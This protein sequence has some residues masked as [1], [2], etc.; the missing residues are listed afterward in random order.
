MRRIRDA[1]LNLRDVAISKRLSRGVLFGQKRKKTMFGPAKSEEMAENI[2]IDTP[3][4]ARK[5]T[6]WLTREWNK[7]KKKGD[8]PRM[9]HLKRAAVLAANRAQVGSQNDNF[10]KKEQ[11]EFAKVEKIYRKW[12]KGKQLP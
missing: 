7:A 11:K 8:R 6:K 10:S 1:L 3:K 4:N 2:K 5:S 9:V 12:Y